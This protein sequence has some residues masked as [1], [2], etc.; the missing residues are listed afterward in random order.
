[1][2]DCIF[3]QIAGGKLPSDLVYE[4]DD[5]VAF[6]D[7]NPQAPTHILIIPRKH[8]ESLNDVH[9]EDASLLAKI[10]LVARELAASEGL[11]A[12]YRVVVNTGPAG[13]QEVMHLHY[14]LLGGRTMGPVG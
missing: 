3:C 2:S 9:E 4:D 13:G 5:I 1:V 8:V 12:G 14:H 10:Q 6:R 11:D 7:V